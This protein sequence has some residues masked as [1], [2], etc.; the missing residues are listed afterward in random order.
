MS[1]SVTLSRREAAT[2]RKKKTPISKSAG[3]RKN[4]AAVLASDGTRARM[5]FTVLP[6][7]AV[8]AGLVAN[9]AF[10]EVRLRRCRARATFDRLICGRELLPRHV[11]RPSWRFA[12][13][14]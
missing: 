12:P 9:D 5:A 7:F 1:K 13:T 4:H 6:P 2:G 14:R 8:V 10:R 3:A 11:R